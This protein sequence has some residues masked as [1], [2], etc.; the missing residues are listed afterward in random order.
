M[1]L[2]LS[3]HRFALLGPRQSNL[4]EALAS[5]FAS[6]TASTPGGDARPVNTLALPDVGALLT[7]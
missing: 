3:M 1:S 4:H 7:R 5:A 2:Q 6:M